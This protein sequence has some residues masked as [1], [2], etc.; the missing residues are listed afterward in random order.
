MDEGTLKEAA[1]KLLT[2]ASGL[3][4]SS[5]RVKVP[6]Q[7]P[8]RATRGP[9]LRAEDSE[10]DENELLDD[11]VSERGVEG[12]VFLGHGEAEDD[13]DKLYV[14]T[15][16]H[17]FGLGNFRLQPQA[18]QTVAQAPIKM[19]PTVTEPSKHMRLML[20]CCAGMGVLD[21]TVHHQ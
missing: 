12:W 1:R 17:Y 7:V 14:K 16:N 15:V 19:V 11:Y 2:A 10:I 5:F 3:R 9:H 13:Q 20:A 18:R 4:R 6:S 8:E 21:A